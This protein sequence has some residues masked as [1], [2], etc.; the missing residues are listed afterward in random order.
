MCYIANFAPP[1]QSEKWI[2]APAPRS[3]RSRVGLGRF[4]PSQRLCAPPPPK[5]FGSFR[6]CAPPPTLKNVPPALL[7]SWKSFGTCL[8]WINGCFGICL[9]MV[10]QGIQDILHRCQRWICWK[11]GWIK[12][13][14]Q[15]IFLSITTQ[16][17]K[18][19]FCVSCLITRH[20]FVWI[21]DESTHCSLPSQLPKL[22]KSGTW[23]FV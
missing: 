6:H 1:P 8:T 13:P 20:S 4:A 15:D 5:Y 9:A 11:C 14:G 10:R 18:C 19:N 23:H 3:L 16:T 17:F 2:D 22:A 21:N 7:W 12:G